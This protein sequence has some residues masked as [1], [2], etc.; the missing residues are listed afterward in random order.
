MSVRDYVDTPNEVY[1]FFEKRVCRMCG[2]S[3]TVEPQTSK[4][5]SNYRNGKYLSMADCT[6][7]NTPISSHSY[8]YDVSFDDPKH[9]GMD[10]ENASFYIDDVHYEL[11][12]SAGC[13]ALI[14]INYDGV[15]TVY[16][17][18]ASVFDFDPWT[19]EALLKKINT[20]RLLK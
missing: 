9:L 12:L 10:E 2:G 20:I 3:L 15:D 4:I 1:S 13:D 18:K 11:L 7:G 17:V 5:N 14:K 8:Y 16:K 19:I 6:V